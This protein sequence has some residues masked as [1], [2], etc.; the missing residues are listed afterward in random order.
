MIDQDD[1]VD[2]QENEDSDEIEETGNESDVE[3]DSDHGEDNSAWED[4]AGFWKRLT[5]E[6]IDSFSFLRTR[7]GR[8]GLVHSFLR[9]LQLFNEG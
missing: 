2:A 5:S 7:A 4:E 8:A 1:E 6:V 9:G 3:D